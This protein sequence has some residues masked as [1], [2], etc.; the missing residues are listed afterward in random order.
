MASSARAS[1]SYLGSPENFASRYS[2]GY[3]WYASRRAASSVSARAAARSPATRDRKASG[4]TSLPYRCSRSSTIGISGSPASDMTPSRVRHSGSA[5]GCLV[6]TS[7]SGCP[8]A[9]KCAALR[10]EVRHIS[11]W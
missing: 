10:P 5:L 7:G 4:M 3:A 11:S 6:S 1:G 8:A 2:G 9:R